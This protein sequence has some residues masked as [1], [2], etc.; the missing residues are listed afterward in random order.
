MNLNEYLVTFD[1]EVDWL[2]SSSDGRR[3]LSDNAK[4][5]RLI[6]IHLGRDHQFSSL[7]CVQNELAAVVSSLQPEGLSE[8]TQVY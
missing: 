4:F 1:R 3:Q 5:Q 2:F 8:N 7:E 6:V